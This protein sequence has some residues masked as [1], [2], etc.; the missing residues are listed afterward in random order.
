MM[1]E[2]NMSRR[3]MPM[4]LAEL[5]DHTVSTT[6]HSDGRPE[7]KTGSCVGRAGLEPA[8]NDYQ[9]GGPAGASSIFL[10]RQRTS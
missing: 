8:T 10:K 2:G 1:Q 9:T 6:T 4:Q 5:L 7:P 3:R